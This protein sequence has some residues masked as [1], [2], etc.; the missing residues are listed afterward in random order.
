MRNISLSLLLA[1]CLET[2]YVCIWR[3]LDA[4]SVVVMVWG[5]V[6]MLVVYQGLLKI[7]AFISRDVVKCHVYLCNGCNG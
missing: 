6:G 5:Y 2:I 1:R 7:V 4:I 3:M